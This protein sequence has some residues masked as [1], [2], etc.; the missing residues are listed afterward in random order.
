MTNFAIILENLEQIRYFLANQKEKYPKVL[1]EATLTMLN[2]EK[3]LLELNF[4][5]NKIQSVFFLVVNEKTASENNIL[6]LIVAK[7]RF[8][9]FGNKISLF[10]NVEIMMKE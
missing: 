5:N 10:E 2:F 7:A 9:K 4:K 1:P 6:D 8:V 3:Q